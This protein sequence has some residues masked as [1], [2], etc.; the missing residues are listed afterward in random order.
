MHPILDGLRR[1]NPRTV[2]GGPPF[3]PDEN[4]ALAQTPHSLLK[5]FYSS[6]PSQ[7]PAGHAQGPSRIN[8]PRRNF[9]SRNPKMTGRDLL[10]PRPRTPKPRGKRAGSTSS[11]RSQHPERKEYQRLHEQKKRERAK[12]LGPCRNCSKPAIPGQSRCETCA[13][14][15][16]QS[17]RRSDANRRAAVNETAATQAGLA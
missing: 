14:H 5:E 3:S 10:P 13:E 15:H 6:T 8:A 4:E 17:R 12:E 2:G 11:F 9:P 1:G 7:Y 16:R